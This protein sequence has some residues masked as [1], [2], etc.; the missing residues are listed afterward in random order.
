MRRSTR[1]EKWKNTSQAPSCALG[2]LG[3]VYT[4]RRSTV[5]S[6]YPPL[7]S[8]SLGAPSCFASTY[9]PLR[10]LSPALFFYRRYVFY[11]SS[12]LF[13]SCCSLPFKG[14][15][16]SASDALYLHIFILFIRTCINFIYS[17]KNP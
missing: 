9:F 13:C 1:A 7:F 15:I 17:S 14:G 11:F 12:F 2:V 6:S 4:A 10:F 16:F 3:V 8:I 5:F